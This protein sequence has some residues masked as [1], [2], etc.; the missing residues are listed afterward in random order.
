M[1][2]PVPV[3]VRAR[4]AD[5]LR[6]DP[7]RL[8]ALRLDPLRLNALRLDPLRLNALRLDPLRLN[9]LRL[10]PLRLDSGEH[11]RGHQQHQGN[12]DFDEDALPGHRPQRMSVTRVICGSPSPKSA[13]SCQVPGASG[14]V[15]TVRRYTFNN[16]MKSNK[17]P[18]PGGILGAG[19]SVPTFPAASTGASSR[20]A[21]R[22]V[23]P[24]L[25]PVSLKVAGNGSRQGKRSAS[26]GR[27]SPLHDTI[28][29]TTKL[30]WLAFPEASTA[31]HL[32]VVA[33]SGNCDPDAGEQLTDGCG[34]RLSV[35][36]TR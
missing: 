21:G 33:P 31:L 28:T 23:M 3:H 13:R 30:P 36:V 27:M 7:L 16:G 25:V 6:L 26:G 24:S 14:R 19:R 1:W 4:E 9:A 10:D 15:S 32:T 20:R 5:A 2:L 11:P 8:N 22:S 29:F 35:A 18:V 17:F 34:S 12:D